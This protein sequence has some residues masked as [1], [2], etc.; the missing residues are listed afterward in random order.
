MSKASF[1]TTILFVV[2]STFSSKA[3]TNSSNYKI[4]NL[5]HLDGNEGWDYLTVDDATDRLFV[6]HGS[7]VQVVD[8]KTNKLIATIKDLKGVH[9]IALANHLNKGFITNGR[10]SSVTVFNLRTYDVLAK[11]SVTGKNPDALIYDKFSQ[12]V[13]VYNGKTSNTTVIDAKTNNIIGTIKLEGKPEESVTNGK[14]LIYVNIEDKNKIQVIDA[15]NLKIVNT[16]SVATGDEPSGLAIDKENNIPFAVCGNKTM[17]VLDAMTGKTITSLTIGDHVDGIAFDNEKKIA[18][19]SN[20]D[21]TITVVK[22]VNKTE[23]KVHEN[24]ST[25]KGA[26]TIAISNKTHHI[27]LPT[28]EFG[29]T[30]KPTKE[31]PR[32]R[33]AI[34]PDTFVILDIAPVK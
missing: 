18:Y 27:Y 12:R 14:G 28:A 19:S 30:P 8:L 11:I 9:G 2:F 13:F 6:S 5:I 17:V 33:P 1:F 24:I 20:G 22:E 21:G 34:K 4:A 16:F 25:Q 10:D 15:N 31:N 3:Q 29:E 7:I 23:F 32:P 26:R